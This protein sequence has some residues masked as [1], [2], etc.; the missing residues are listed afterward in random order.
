MFFHITM[1]HQNLARIGRLPGKDL[2]YILHQPVRREKHH[3]ISLLCF[4][5]CTDIVRDFFV[6]FSVPPRIFCAHIPAKCEKSLCLGKRTLRINGIVI[7]VRG[8]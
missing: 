4:C 7:L 1:L 3:V 8:K 2:I 5:D 6:F